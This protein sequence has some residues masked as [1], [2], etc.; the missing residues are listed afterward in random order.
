MH[1]VNKRLQLA[2]TDKPDEISKR[3]YG[4]IRIIY[5]DFTYKL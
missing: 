1:I 3:K 2:Q 4:I 5:I